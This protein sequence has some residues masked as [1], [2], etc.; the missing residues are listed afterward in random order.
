ML[1]GMIQSAANNGLVHYNA[2]NSVVKNMAN[3]TTTGYKAERFD[4]YLDGPNALKGSLQTDTTAGQQ[5]LTQNEFD[6]ALKNPNAY[7]MVTRPDGSQ[8]YTKDGRFR[9]NRDRILVT[10]E[11]DIVGQGIQIP[12]DFG[13]LMV[14]PTGE[15]SIKKKEDGY[16]KVIGQL[17]VARFDN[18]A[19]LVKTSRNQLLPSE[20][21]GTPTL[22]EKPQIMQGALER[23]NVDLYDEV[24]NSMRI[25]AGVITNMR[26][27]KLMDELL[28]QAIRIR[29]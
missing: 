8:A 18:P 22:E 17:S 10:Q 2:L 14:S 24:H 13:K 27:V 6:L 20:E 28:N 19:G 3:Y 11:G 9:L 1:I 25:N 21:S 15:V 12:Q 16:K 7:F 4:L 23:S 26:L 5:E 29:Q